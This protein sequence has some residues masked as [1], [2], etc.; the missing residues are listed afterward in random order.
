MKNFLVTGIVASTFASTVISTQA[1]ANTPSKASKID[2]FSTDSRQPNSGM[3]DTSNLDT[4]PPKSQIQAPRNSSSDPEP[5][6]KM[7]RL[8][9][10]YPAYCKPYLFNSEPG[11]WQFKQD[12]QRCLYGG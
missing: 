10:D 9:K 1:F 5:T 2:Y 8:N 7:D 4:N 6:P 11:S 12:I 3:S